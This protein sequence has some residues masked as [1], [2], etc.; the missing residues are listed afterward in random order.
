MRQISLQ[1][2]GRDWASSYI[3]ISSSGRHLCKPSPEHRRF[4]RF[5]SPEKCPCLCYFSLFPSLSLSLSLPLSLSFKTWICS[6]KR[7]WLSSLSVHKFALEELKWL[8]LCTKDFS[9]LDYF[10]FFQR[11]FENFIDNLDLIYFQ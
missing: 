2:T 4:A 1:K 9:T 7:P 6:P 5:P 3:Q 8:S 11:F 10:Y